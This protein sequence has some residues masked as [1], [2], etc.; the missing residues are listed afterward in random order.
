MNKTNLWIMSGIPG[1]GKSYFAKNILMTD[2]SWEYV[3]RDEVRFSMVKENEE[4]FSKENAV[5]KEFCNRIIY[6]LGCDEY[7]NVIAD[8]THLDEKSRMKLIKRVCPEEMGVNVFCVYFNTPLDV[9]DSRNSAREGRACVPKS[10]VHRMYYQ[11][12]HPSKDN[13][14][15]TG[16]LEV[17]N[18]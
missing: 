14:N 17:S 8:A 12:T 15:Y 4:Y 7:H 2:D 11:H 18:S 10:V 1:S 16:I 5:F 9:C 6:A 13:F 3:S